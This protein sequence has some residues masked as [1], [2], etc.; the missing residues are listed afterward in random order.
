MLASEAF[1]ERLPFS[2]FHGRLLVLGGLGYLFDA[3]DL[4]ILSFVLP[5]LIVQWKLTAA[6]AG[7]IASAS[8][9]GGIAGAFAAGHLGDAFGRRRVMIGALALYTLATFGSAAAIGFASFLV[10]RI[11][12]G[13]GTSAESVIIAPYLSEF[14]A[15]RF[16]GR[17][18]GTITGFF[19]FG[20][21]L[22]AVLGY[23]LVSPTS[24]SWRG[25]LVLT[26]LPIFVAIWWRRLPES[27]AWLE[28]R[29]RGVEAH[30]VCQR[31]A[32]SIPD[33]AAR[34]AVP[35]RAE[36]EN[37]GV[38]R[39]EDRDHPHHAP[40]AGF[41]DLFSRGMLRRTLVAAIVWTAMGLSY[42]AFLTWIPSLLV[43][44]GF[45]LSHSFGF[46]ILIFAAQVPGFFSAAWLNDRVGTRA[47]I[48]LYLTIGSIAA[49]VL[50]FAATSSAIIAASVF[51]SFG[52]NGVYAGLYAYT[53]ALFP[54]RS[55][56]SGQ[57]FAIG[58]SRI[59]AMCSP[60]LVGV[61]YPVVGFIGVFGTTVAILGTAL[62]AIL[63][64]APRDIGGRAVVA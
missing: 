60:F 55:R 31:I 11:V 51:L 13:I 49:L 37:A 16:R 63:F 3:L 50:A 54:A 45:T 15:K 44:R 32:D 38:G 46:S 4:G 34:A 30:A 2:R 36:F 10:A 48:A 24:T 1:I 43:A 42:Y 61:L 62:V 57:G 12:A 21:L 18:V 56:A 20:F 17:F 8:Y 35:Q 64:L 7:L 23:V 59:G 22:A 5:V 41:R 58:L 33:P 53:P 27:P 52:M 40:H 19:S 39:D 9:I 28:S 26:G 47:V 29:G 14:A 25:V 6:Q